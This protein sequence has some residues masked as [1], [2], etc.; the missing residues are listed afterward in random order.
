MSL[1]CKKTKLM[2][3]VSP[4]I[5]LLL[6]I[7]WH[8]LPVCPMKLV[9]NVWM[10]HEQVLVG[11]SCVDLDASVVQSLAKT[12]ASNGE[13]VFVCGRK[14][15]ITPKLF[16]DNELLWNYTTKSGMLYPDSNYYRDK[17]HNLWIHKE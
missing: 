5:G 9:F 12:L 11:V 2:L 15:M 8:W 6:A 16:F 3:I 1:A 17:E 14:V 13:H 4:A 7:A 10:G